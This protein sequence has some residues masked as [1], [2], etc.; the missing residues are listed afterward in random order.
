MKFKNI[1]RKTLLIII[2]I[3]IITMILLTSIIVHPNSRLLF[4]MLWII[5]F[6]LIVEIIAIVLF[7]KYL[8]KS[9][10]RVNELAM[11]IANGDLAQKLNITSESEIGKIENHLNKISENIRTLITTITDNSADVSLISEGLTAAVEETTIRLEDINKFVKKVNSSVQESSS[12]NEEIAASI[13]EIDSSVNELALKAKDGSDLSCQIKN[14]ASIIKTK[15]KESN[16]KANLLYKEKQAK[17]LRSIE[18]GNV[19]YEIKN[20]AETIGNIANQTNLLALNAAIEAARAGEQG[21]GFSIVADEVRKLAEQSSITVTSIQETVSKVQEVF[22]NL[23]SNAQ[24][25]LNFID[26]TIISDYNDSV[27]MS[28]QYEEDAE[29]VSS[30]SNDIAIMTEEISK[31]ISQVSQ[32]VQ[33]LVDLTQDSAE[34][35]NEI[36]TSVEEVAQAMLEVSE[37]VKNQAESAETLTAKVENFNVE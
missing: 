7:T 17:I 15:S 34:G 32:A 26:E 10:N 33:N 35:S 14:R 19:V 22:R 1:K 20:M 25:I 5:V 13:E 28:N 2:P 8:T 21:R 3:F 24:E 30:M 12:S 23:S 18:D 37:I 16:E 36:S 27:K 9:I 4:N 11:A 6:F 31:T 29:Y